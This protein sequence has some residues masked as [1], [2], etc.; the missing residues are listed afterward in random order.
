MVLLVACLLAGS[1][2][3][4]HSTEHG[5]DVALL[6]DSSGSMKQSDPQGLRKPA[7]K[8]F[9]SL[10][11]EHDHASVISFSDQ[12]YPVAFPQGVVSDTEQA[13]LHAAVDKVSSRGAYTNLYAAID[14]AMELLG[15]GQA[16]KQRRL[17]VLMSDG[18]MDL[19]NDADSEA[20]SKKLFAELL[21]Q[22]K[23]ANIELQTI[24]FTEQ[25][26][27][28]LLAKIARETGGRF[29]VANS[30][31]ELHSTFSK[32]YENN[33]QPNMLP[34]DEGHFHVDPAISEVTVI[35]SKANADVTLSLTDPYS[36]QYSAAQHPDNIKWSSSPLFDLITIKRPQAGDWHL[37]ASDNNNKAYVITNLKLGMSIKPAQPRMDETI[38]LQAWLEKDGEVLINEAILDKLKIS[39]ET[40]TPGGKVA[41]FPLH[42]E[43]TRGGMGTSTGI[44]SAQLSA[45]AAGQYEIVLVANSGTFKRK[46]NLV[47]DV[48]PAA[49]TKPTT[50]AST[51]KEAPSATADAEPSNHSVE[52]AD[53]IDL[54]RALLIFLGVNVVLALI[55]GTAIAWHR[56]KK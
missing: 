22:V 46:R 12:G 38:E 20:Q 30:D 40:I 3:A 31:T 48:L 4:S 47:F 52:A 29:Y 16:T 7:A 26:D 42:S 41:Q 27:K 18:K 34:F 28:A 1:A 44:F 37:R 36:E 14:T 54:T 33:T 5:L 15:S 53:N 49:E 32:I 2:V 9:L 17:I 35:G 10:L 51:S 24:A 23:Q 56:R 25:S 43:E 19:G 8:L 13:S 50:R 11:S 45:P 6:L 21:P 55:I 39:G